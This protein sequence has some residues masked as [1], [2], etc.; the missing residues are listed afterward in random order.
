[1]MQREHCE[2]VAL[3]NWWACEANLRGLDKR[4]LMAIP[5][6]GKRNKV[7]GGRLKAEGVRAGAPDY[8]LAIP[9]PRFAG[10]F[11]ELKTETGRPSP[12]QKEMIDLLNKHSYCAVVSFGTLAA[13]D[14]I[15]AYLG[16]IVTS[17]FQPAA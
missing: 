17:K 3:M 2:A 9:T 12:S 6:G 1:M 13:M 10:L 8:L 15:K 7:T 11:I 16:P 14:A 4:L 5:N